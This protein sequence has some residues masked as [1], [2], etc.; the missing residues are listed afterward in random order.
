[1]NWFGAS[2]GWTTCWSPRRWSLLGSAR[3]F[4]RSPLIW[5]VTRSPVFF[6]RVGFVAHDP[7]LSHIDWIVCSSWKLTSIVCSWLVRWEGHML[8]SG[9]IAFA[10]GWWT[11]VSWV[12]LARKIA[13]ILETLAHFWR[14]IYVICGNIGWLFVHF[15]WVVMLA[16][17]FNG[18]SRSIWRQSLRRAVRLFIAI[19]GERVAPLLLSGAR[20]RICQHGLGSLVI[21]LEALNSFR[22]VVFWIILLMRIL[23]CVVVGWTMLPSERR[24]VL[25]GGSM[26][27]VW[28]SEFSIA[29]IQTILRGLTAWVFTF[30]AIFFFFF[31]RLW[32]LLIRIRLLVILILN[33]LGRF[34]IHGFHRL[35]WSVFL[36]A[37]LLN[38]LLF[39]LSVFCFLLH[40]SHYFS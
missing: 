7:H 20:S 36:L 2:N 9:V 12:A 35:F 33:F 1:M 27:R 19:S 38:G 39:L 10:E 29:I 18:L 4:N 31:G 37:C 34:S 15:V 30:G 26:L 6:A 11:C 25:V 8:V 3:S 24:S 22:L 21:W 5:I 17:P 16:W 23:C 14:R 32:K 40:V 13:L 28:G